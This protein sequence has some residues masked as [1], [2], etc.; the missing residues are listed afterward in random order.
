MSPSLVS[1]LDRASRA[2]GELSGV[3]ETIPNPHLL[4][5]PL[6]RR[7]AVLSSR[8]EGTIASLSDVFAY[9][10]ESRHRPG[11]DVAEVINYVKALEQGIAR[12]DTLPI[13]LRLVNELHARLLYGVRGQES[14]P[15]EF[16]KQQVWIGTPGFSIGA[17]K[18]IPPPPEYLPALFHDWESFV[19]ES[20]DM[21]PLV[22][23]A[24]MHYQ[25]EA[26][27][28]YSDGN[29]RIGRLLITLF[30]SASGL[31]RIPL[32][33]LSAYF[34]RNRES[35]YEELFNVGATGD[36]ERWLEY[37]LRGVHQEAGDVVE[38][39]R[40]IRSL[41]D[42]WRGLLIGRREAA[43]VLRLLEEFLARP[44]LT[45]SQAAE[46]LG[47]PAPPGRDR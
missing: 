47:L 45:A 33:Y 46:A 27:H 2:V 9:E 17:A 6:L 39:I 20:N 31:L 32:L 26:I 8:I 22:R 1:L 34:E 38:R 44:I 23:C 19:N 16:R 14:R 15:G 18:F 12:L 13:S 5:R 11:G 43:S 4:M 42:E 35:Y 7:E 37:F 29:G 25:I 3:G 10:A 28:P 24:F 40:R 36:W 30:L 41:Q 21:P